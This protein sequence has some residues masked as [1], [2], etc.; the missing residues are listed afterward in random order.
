[1][2]AAVF[3]AGWAAEALMPR[4]RAVVAGAHRGRGREVISLDWPSA[5]HERGRKMWAVPNAW[6]HGEPRLASSQTGV[7]AVVAT[8]GRLDGIEVVG[9][10]PD[11]HDAAMAYLQATEH[12]RS[13]QLE[14]ARGR[15]WELLHE[16]MPRRAYQQRP[17]SAREV[18]TPLEQEGHVPQAQYAFDKGVLNRELTRGIEHAGKH[19]VSALERSRHLQWQGQWRRVEAVAEARRH[20]HPESFRP[21]RVRCR[22]GETQAGWAFTQVG[23]L[24]RD[25]RKRLVMVHENEALRD[26]PRLLLTAALHWERGRV[27]ETGSDRWTSDILHAFGKQGCGL[28]TAQVRKAE[29]VKRH[30]RLSGVAQ[31]LLQ[32]AP[33]S[34]SATER[35]TFAQ[36]ATP[37][38]QKVRT[39]AREAL[40]SLLKRVEQWLAQGHSCEH[41]WE[42]LM[43]A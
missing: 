12:A 4:P 24:T 36:G 18:V 38:G 2:H 29:A 25:G 32:Q 10:P 14:T 6:A 43:P 30:F 27:L 17:A 16:R 33:A 13:P 31:S 23:R 20:A 3:E 21:R 35:F 15:L 5:H 34:G 39:I 28:E 41:M 7:T 37:I 19:W 40:Q 22:N 9:Q 1:M 26:A 8:R 11:R 42:V